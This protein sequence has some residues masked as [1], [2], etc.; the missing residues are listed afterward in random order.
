MM[1]LFISRVSS[2]IVM[3]S[4]MMM[5]IFLLLMSFSP[6]YYV[7]AQQP[8]C[9]LY[10]NVELKPPAYGVVVVD[11]NTYIND[12]DAVEWVVN[13]DGYDR[14]YVWV[15][16][17]VW[18]A[19]SAESNTVIVSTHTNYSTILS[20]DISSKAQKTS[21]CMHVVVRVT[22]PIRVYGACFNGQCSGSGLTSCTG[23]NIHFTSAQK[24]ELEML[25]MG[26]RVTRMDFFWA[27]VERSS[28]GVYD[29]SGYDTLTA[30]LAKPKT[31][32]SVPIMPYYILDYTNPLYGGGAPP[33]RVPDAT[34]GFVSFARAG[35]SRYSGQG[36]IWE[37]WNE[38]NGGFWPPHANVTEYSIAGMAVGQALK[39]AYPKERFVGPATS[40]VDLNFLEGT[41]QAGLLS[42]WDAV[43]VHPY[44]MSVPETVN[45]DYAKLRALIRQYKPMDKLYVPILAGEWGYSIVGSWPFSAYQQGTF[46]VREWLIN[47]YNQVP[48]SIYYDWHDDGTSTTDPEHNFGT[49]QNAYYPSSNSSIKT[50]YEPKPAFFT[51]ATFQLYMR[52][53]RYTNRLV[54]NPSSSNDGDNID[55]EYA[56]VFSNANGNMSAPGLMVVWTT[57]TSSS[58]PQDKA[59]VKVSGYSDASAAVLVHN[60]YGNVTYSLTADSTG[61]LALSLTPG[62]IYYIVPYMGNRISQLAS[63]CLQTVP[64]DTITRY[65]KDVVVP[66]TFVNKG[67]IISNVTITINTTYVYTSFTKSVVSPSVVIAPFDGATLRT[68]IP[69]VNRDGVAYIT[70]QVSFPDFPSLSTSLYLRTNLVMEPAPLIVS[71][72]S[73]MMTSSSSNSDDGEVTIRVDNP[74]GLEIT[75]V[76]NSTGGVQPSLQKISYQE[77]D[78][79]S[80]YLTY[81]LQSSYQTPFDITVSIIDA[82][83]Q[84]QQQGMLGYLPSTMVIQGDDFTRFPVGNTLQ[85]DD[86]QVYVDGNNTIHGSASIAS[87]LPPSP[88]NDLPISEHVLKIDFSWPAGWK[89]LRV[90]PQTTALRKIAGQPSSFGFWAFGIGSGANRAIRLLDSSGQVFQLLSPTPDRVAGVWQWQSFDLLAGSTIHWGGANDGKVHYPLSWDTV[91]LYDTLQQS[92]SGTV[93]FTA[94]S[95]YQ[96]I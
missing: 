73:P 35:V 96:Q 40:G 27:G 72:L 63:N 34:S 44:R 43:S 30:A 22:L 89:F 24:G 80:R 54:T 8:Q 69:A 9:L 59:I 14:D 66:I 51:A 20:V 7:N 76:V 62:E 55:D 42:F 81:S 49:V 45:E 77:G 15:E 26:F 52:G 29:W 3:I 95:A 23:T 68:S 91:F 48:V 84:Q 12:A 60:M 92:C 56:L 36:I 47:L 83:S 61:T 13:P 90:Y 32:T 33:G 88:T 28:R 5:M 78:R 10:D 2:L 18:A 37:M 50:V 17:E 71:V 53:Y 74:K 87:S 70:V 6:L 65:G 31:P 67:T 39:G 41:F 64:I 86:Y 82:S 46:L 4:T 11:V 79:T 16:V 57:A 38:P 21:P 94:P 75:A 25:N 1:K 19:S 85:P 58:P 93:Y